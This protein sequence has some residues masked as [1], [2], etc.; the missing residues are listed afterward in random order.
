MGLLNDISQ[1]WWQWMGPMLLQVT[2]LILIISGLD[3][4]LKKWAWPQVR[5]GLWILVMIKLLIPPNWSSP[6][7]VI[8]HFQPHIKQA[9]FS[10]VEI[11]KALDTQQKVLPE[12]TTTE[13]RTAHTLAESLPESENKSLSPLVTENRENPVWQTWAMGIWLFGILIYISVLFGK[14]KKLR[15][16]HQQ[17]KD[18]DI[19]QWFHKILVQTAQRL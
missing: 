7:S 3:L 5:Y 1:L 16:W 19:P 4:L 9:V 10:R 11:Q 8:S 12:R 14:M 15:H 13:Q 2:V 6:S 17:Q 18:K